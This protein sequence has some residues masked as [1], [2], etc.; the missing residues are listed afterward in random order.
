MRMIRNGKRI[1]YQSK[2]RKGDR[3]IINNGQLHQFIAFFIK[4][5]QN[6]ENF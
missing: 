4:I 3:T 5:R 6:T 2:K 1:T